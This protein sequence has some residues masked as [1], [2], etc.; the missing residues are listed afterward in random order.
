MSRVD[1]QNEGVGTE[2]RRKGHPILLPG[3]R[4]CAHRYALLRSGR[5]PRDRNAGDEY[6][7]ECVVC[8]ED[9][10]AAQ[11]AFVVVHRPTAGGKRYHRVYCAACLLAYAFGLRGPGDSFCRREVH[12]AECLD[13]YTR[14]PWPGAFLALI[15]K[16]ARRR[17][18]LRREG[19]RLLL[20]HKENA[21]AGKWARDRDPRGWWNSPVYSGVPRSPLPF[22][23]LRGRSRHQ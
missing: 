22:P 9:A 15:L 17:G 4:A 6:F 2:P 7:E 8:H 13:P 21:P 11:D 1:L 18:L 5:L 12:L 10:S 19:P 14:E 16:Q 3:Q 23:G 20:R